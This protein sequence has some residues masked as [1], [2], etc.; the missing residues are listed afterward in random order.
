MAIL[1]VSGHP[2]YPVSSEQ[3]RS[4]VQA[5]R[6]TVPIKE[7]RRLSIFLRIQ[8]SCKG[9]ETQFF[10]M[11]LFGPDHICEK[12]SI[13]SVP[14]RSGGHLFHPVRYVTGLQRRELTFKISPTAFFQPN[15]HQ[16]DIL[17]TTALR[18]IGSPRERILDLYAGT[19]TLGM[20]FSSL[21]KQVVAV[22]LNPYACL[23]AEENRVLNQ[24]DNLTIH[25]GDAGKTLA[26]LRERG[27]V[28]DLVLLDPP[29]TGLDKTALTQL[30]ELRAKEILYISCNPT[31][32]AENI[33][34]LQSSG[35]QL[36]QLQIVDQFPHT[37]HVETI[38]HLRLTPSVPD[39]IGIIQAAATADEARD[40]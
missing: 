39:K 29:R 27:E 17:F 30:S 25:C 35:Y 8:Q 4:F 26:A 2:A 15:T 37:P 22:E 1:T 13:G 28:F 23:D 31:T 40:E 32:Q 38:A 20:V 34:Q 36:I 33:V 12:L 18:M 11:H 19:A 21:A 16:A 5:L 6:E 3:L 10:E 9:F 7:E 14:N 24:I